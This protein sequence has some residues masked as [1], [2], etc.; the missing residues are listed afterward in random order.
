MR[1]LLL[2]VCLAGCFSPELG[3]PSFYCHEE[4]TPA[5]PDGQKCVGGRC[6]AQNADVNGNVG[7]S[8][9]DA[10]VPD[11]LAMGG[12]GGGAGDLASPLAPHDLAT[13]SSPPDLLSCVGTGGDC[14][15]HNNKV[16]CSSYCI[17]ASNTC[18]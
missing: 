6:Y 12:W 14:T 5:C 4:D 10:G 2:V 3:S 9:D 8:S 17:Y 18:K 1:W 16:C 15:Y 13:P 11:D 7:G